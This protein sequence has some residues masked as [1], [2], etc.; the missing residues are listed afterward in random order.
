MCN[1]VVWD[2]LMTRNKVTKSTNSSIPIYSMGLKDEL[3][4]YYYQTILYRFNC[5]F[6]TLLTPKMLG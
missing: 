3:S 6:Y 2:E 5:F 1:Y 4:Y